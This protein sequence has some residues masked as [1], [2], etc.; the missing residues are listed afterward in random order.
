[1]K[2][3]HTLECDFIA[4]PLSVHVSAPVQPLPGWGSKALKLEFK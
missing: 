1:M 2:G 3:H 4:V